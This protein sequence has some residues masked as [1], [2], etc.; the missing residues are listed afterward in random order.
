MTTQGEPGDCRDWILAVLS[1][2]R[3]SLTL[4]VEDC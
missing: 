3:R 1:A 4:D 2:L